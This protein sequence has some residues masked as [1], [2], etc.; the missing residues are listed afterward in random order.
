[1]CVKITYEL[2]QFAGYFNSRFK[3]WLQHAKN[4]KIP[5]PIE[6][7]PGMPWLFLVSL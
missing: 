1:M 3:K 4:K 7:D 2:K 6:F 5:G